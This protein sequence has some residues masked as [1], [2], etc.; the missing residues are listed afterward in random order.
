MVQS[1]APGVRSRLEILERGC[2]VAINWMDRIASIDTALALGS[3][4][5][6][7]AGVIQ[8]RCCA[9]LQS[10]PERDRGNLSR[11]LNSARQNHALPTTYGA[12]DPPRSCATVV[13]RL[14]WVDTPTNT[15]AG[16][17]AQ[18]DR[19]T[20]AR[21]RCIQDDHERQW[22]DHLYASPPLPHPMLPARAHLSAASIRS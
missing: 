13:Q 3:L 6:A 5:L 19:T 22:S 16:A 11:Q 21:Y 8:G 2:H 10:T 12:D 15:A 18:W 14:I 1:L 4:A 7:L 17:Q 20:A 9:K